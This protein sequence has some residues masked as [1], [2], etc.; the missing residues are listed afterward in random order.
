MKLWMSSVLQ[1]YLA[2]TFMISDGSM[3]NDL[4]LWNVWQTLDI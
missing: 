2:D 1:S 4:N 3:P